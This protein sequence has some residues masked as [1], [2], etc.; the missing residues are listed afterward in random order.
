MPF[1]L[2]MEQAP[3]GSVLIIENAA[4]AGGV[5]GTFE[6][7]ASL[8]EAKGTN[9]IGICLDTCHTLAQGEDIRTPEAVNITLNRFLSIFGEGRLKA[10]HANDSIY[11]INSH[12]DRHANIGEGEI[13]LEG[14]KALLHHPLSGS[15]PWILEVPGLD[16]KGP[17]KEN[18]DRLRSL[19]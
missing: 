8:L 14:F 4:G 11:P 1:L 18:I 9:K 12:R 16:H 13:G 15:V 10:I 5:I 7:I 17:D 6:E 3:D 2:I 19:F